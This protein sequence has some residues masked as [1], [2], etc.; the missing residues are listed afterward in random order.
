MP[1]N[2]PGALPGVVTVLPEQRVFASQ[3]RYRPS[4]P[5]GS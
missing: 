5:E 2:L 1:G 4:P 3:T